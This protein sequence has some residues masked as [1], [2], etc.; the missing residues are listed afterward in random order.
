[1]HR[2][3]NIKDTVLDRSHKSWEVLINGKCIETQR[4]FFYVL[5][6]KKKFPKKMVEAQFLNICV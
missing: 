2:N 1:M 5:L 3:M 6:N 4:I